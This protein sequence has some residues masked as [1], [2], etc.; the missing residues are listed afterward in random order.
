MKHIYK[1]FWGLAVI[2]VARPVLGVNCQPSGCTGT[3]KTVGM[4]SQTLDC[5]MVNI[6]CYGG[7]YRVDSCASCDSTHTKTAHTVTLDGLCSGTTVT[8]YTCD[9]GGQGPITPIQTCPQGKY[10][11]GTTCTSCPSPGTTGKMGGKTKSDCYIPAGA[12]FS[13]TLGSGTYASN[14]PWIE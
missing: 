2:L 6:N 3:E 4:L 8:Y 5:A 7:Q 12:A 1:I 14:C 11:D 9:L 13:D 10:G